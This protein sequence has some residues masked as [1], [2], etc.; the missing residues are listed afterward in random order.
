[1]IVKNLTKILDLFLHVDVRKEQDFFILKHTFGSETHHPMDTKCIF[2]SFILKKADPFNPSGITIRMSYQ[3]AVD[4]SKKLN[5]LLEEI[6]LKVEEQ[7]L[8]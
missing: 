5:K 6:R 3:Q 8:K 1:M 7:T 4:F 2:V